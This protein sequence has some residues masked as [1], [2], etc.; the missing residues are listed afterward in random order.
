MLLAGG[1]AM[2][3]AERLPGTGSGWIEGKD[4]KRPRLY[5]IDCPEGRFDLVR[6]KHAKFAF[7]QGDTVLGIAAMALPG[8][9]G[10]NRLKSRIELPERLPLATR[11]F[12][13]LLVEI[14]DS[15]RM[16]ASSP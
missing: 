1:T 4:G 12:V 10:G 6:V 14:E 9:G 2:V 16:G 13:A 15:D 11:L 7:C 8:S 5:V 3:T